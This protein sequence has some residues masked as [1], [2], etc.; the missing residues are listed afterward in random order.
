MIKIVRSFHI[1]LKTFFYLILVYPLF[2]QVTPTVGLH[3]NTPRIFC[4]KGANIVTKPGHLIENGELVIRDGIIESVGKVSKIPDDAF[5]IDLSGKTIYP[6]FIESFYSSK[7]TK[8]KDKDKKNSKQVKSSAIDHWNSKVKPDY[9]LLGE[10]KPKSKEIE[11]LRKLGFTT[12]QLTPN[13]GIFRGTAS[14]I[15]LGNWHADMIIGEYSPAQIIAFEYGGWGDKNYPNSL[16]GCVAL[17]RQTLL[18]VDWYKNAWD[19]YNRFPNDNE[20]PEITNSLKILNE[21]LTSENPVCF[22][23]NEELSALRAEKIAKEFDIN[24]WLRGSGYEYRRLNEISEISPFIILP[25]D[26]P[27]KPDVSTWESTLQVN[28][29]DLRHWDQAP[30]NPQRLVD[31]GIRFSL[32]TD[33]MDNRLDFRNNLL[34]SV[35]RGF[36]K[37]KALE[38]LT[39]IP[40]KALKLENVLGTIEVGKIANFFVTDGDYFDKDTKVEEVW[41][42]G[43]KY[44]VISVPNVNIRGTWSMLWET[45]K[46]SRVD[47]LKFSGS[48]TNPKGEFIYGGQPIPLQSVNYE[49][50]LISF[51]LEGDSLQIP[52]IVRFSGM[53]LEDFCEGQGRMPKGDAIKWFASKIEQE[54]IE[55]TESDS[56]ETKNE[57]EHPSNL[58]P[59]FPEGAFGWE[60]LP[61]QPS[62]VLIKNATLWTCS[63]DGI[64]KNSDLLVK[65]GK[66]WKTGKNLSIS[67]SLKDAVIID[68]KGKHITPGLIDCHN[69]SA[70]FSIN[71]GTQ[72]VTAEVR[73]EDV[74]N[75]DDIAIYRELAGGLTTANILHGSANAIGGQ[76]AVIKL[77]WG[78]TP[79]ELLFHIAPKG[80]KFALGENVKQS[81][82][83]D[84]YTTRYPQTRMGVEQIIR[85]AFHA[86][87]EYQKE[88]NNYKSRK[89]STLKKIPPRKDLELEALVEILEGERLVHCHSYRQDEIL[90]LIRI[91]ED[92]GFRI[93]TFQHVLEG[94]KVAEAIASHGAGASTFT[95]WWAYKYEVIDAIPFNGALMDQ[96]GVVTSFNSDSGELARRLNTEAAKAVKYGGLSHEEALKFVTINPAIQLGIDQ[97]VGSLETGKDA[98]F[99]IWSDNPL[100][101]FAVC[102]QTWIDGINYFNIVRDKKMRV[103]QES[104][105]NKLIQKV[106]S[107][108]ET[109]NSKM[110]GK[111]KRKPRTEPFTCTEGLVE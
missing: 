86:A 36:S 101:S 32:T 62:I 43:E 12:A 26:F 110:Y 105:R 51:Q 54:I 8:K 15:H 107:S 14:V 98:D 33:G 57:A 3:K 85:D 103:I 11:T 28:N 81:N 19:T 2:S 38:A 55:G 50:S 60:V 29:E 87:Q 18:D 45:R 77:R 61:Q 47:T 106:L 1:S 74:I 46:T 76:N 40:A 75:S 96:V 65:N 71:E 111:G 5:E 6:G 31:S 52:G 53:V 91:A 21:H 27:E 13:T 16:L 48:L 90:M 66:I 56:V 79:D 34:Q 67:G 39:T 84:D 37:E 92:F 68:A 70:A 22:I 83:G 35:E 69:H 97:G 25:L 49:K 73:I 4:F 104:E 99:V 41:I 109:G 78:K 24:L 20:Q 88:W 7:K 58:S 82:W 93:G 94:Y 64:L 9:N 23:T 63:K 72:S 59:K 95:D 102:E 42:K 108:E 17:I 100:S 44:P 80:I 89:S 30:D 10:F